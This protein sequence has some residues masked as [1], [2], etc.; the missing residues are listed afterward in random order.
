MGSSTSVVAQGILPAKIDLETFKNIAPEHFSQGVFNKLKGP[1]N[2]ISIDRFITF[3]T[4][5]AKDAFVTHDWGEDELKRNNHLRA[6]KLNKALQTTK[7]IKTWF[8]EEQMKGDIKEKM[9]D[10]IIFASFIIILI[11]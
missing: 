3:A 7:G 10:G 4:M 5:E 6:A 9:A 8:D 1:D 11:T 2:L